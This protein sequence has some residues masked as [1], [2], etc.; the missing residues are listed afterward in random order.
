MGALI[1]ILSMAMDPFF[2]QIA[3]Y[4]PGPVGSGNSSVI[5]SRRLF[6][7]GLDS[8]YAHPQVP[9]AMRAAIYQGLFFTGATNDTFAMSAL[10]PR[11]NCASGNCTYPEFETLAVC[12]KCAN[13]TDRL[14]R[15]WTNEFGTDTYNWSLPNGF[16]TGGIDVSDGDRVVMK[17]SASYNATVLTAG[18]PLLNYSTIQIP[19]T[20]TDTEAE[21]PNA[22]IAVSAEEC[23]LYWCVKKYRSSVVNGLLNET[24]VAT[25]S[26]GGDDVGALYHF[27]PPG[28][29]ASFE[30]PVDG[31]MNATTTWGPTYPKGTINGTFL[32]NKNASNLIT[33]FFKDTIEG[34]V[35]VNGDPNGD[36]HS[37]APIVQRFQVG[38]LPSVFDMLALSMSTAVRGT[39]SD[40]ANTAIGADNVTVTGLSTTTVTYIRVRWWWITL[41]VALE[42][43]TILLFA[44]TLLE[45]RRMRVWKTSALAVMMHGVREEELRDEKVERCVDMEDVAM[46]K[47][48]R[49]EKGVDGRERLEV[50]RGVKA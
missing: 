48:V 11:P 45:A 28:S 25:T 42:V 47:R 7:A 2:Q 24:L 3:S 6:D 26:D 38:G 23:M 39:G 34:E 5:P 14:F 43:A 10:A 44:M 31:L 19:D 15:N 40:T 36:G 17:A 22:T 1:T 18:F 20:F 37:T 29:N 21:G 16:N 46:R 41:P 32:V 9:P 12:S 27:K 50:W 33:Q 13:V 8:K 35:T 4:E 49:L 30:I